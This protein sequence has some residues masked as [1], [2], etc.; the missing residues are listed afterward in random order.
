[1]Q[2]E[3]QLLKAIVGQCCGFDL[4]GR[5]DTQLHCLRNLPSLSTTPDSVFLAEAIP[6]V[7]SQREAEEKIR[8]LQTSLTY[9]A[10]W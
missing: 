6:V 5:N 9:G 1:V 8:T 3:L 4:T 10:W 7:N 2:G